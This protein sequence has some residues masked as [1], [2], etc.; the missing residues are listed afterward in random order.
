MTGGHRVRLRIQVVTRGGEVDSDAQHFI[1]CGRSN[2][3]SPEY[4]FVPSRKSA[5][6]P[7]APMFDLERA[8]TTTEVVVNG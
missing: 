7:G 1:R 4:W 5:L 3:V 8:F 6:T 2:A